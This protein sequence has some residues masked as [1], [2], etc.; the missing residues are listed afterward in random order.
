MSYEL[1]P[2]QTELRKM[3]EHHRKAA[4]EDDVRAGDHFNSPDFRARMKGRAE[5]R[6]LIVSKLGE[7]LKTLDEKG[8]ST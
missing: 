5:I 4:V 2:I 6:R 8:G 1:G 7:V 3:V